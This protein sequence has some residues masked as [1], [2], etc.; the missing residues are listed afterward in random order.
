MR[1]RLLRG[2]YLGEYLVEPVTGRVSGPGSPQHLPSKAV[3]VLLCLASNPR[4][5]ISRDELLQSVWGEGGGSNEA[6]SH[7]VGTL[8]QVFNDHPD[9]PKLIQT[10][11]K[12]GYRLLEDPRLAEEGAAP[13][14]PVKA[15]SGGVGLFAELKRRGVIETGLAY[16]LVGWLLIQ[17]AD[18]TFGNLG[19]PSW[20]PIFITYLVLAGFPIALLLAWF[21]DMTDR[22]PALDRGAGSKPAEKTFSRTYLSVVGAL[23]LASVG[24]FIYDSYVGL[25]VEPTSI[26]AGIRDDIA[27]TFC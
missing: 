26:D 19:L 2:F 7:A 4:S 14:E 3:E 20:A 15:G 10:L 12:R 5:L 21:L 16:L 9:D 11:P 6:L 13:S 23:M 22:G 25:P 27:D 17:I 1:K 8:R 18:V 24:V